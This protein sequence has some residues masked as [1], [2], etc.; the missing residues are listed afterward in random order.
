MSI[1]QTADDGRIFQSDDIA[2]AQYGCACVD[3]EHQFGLV[4]HHLA[5]CTDAGGEILVPQAESGSGEVIQAAHQSG[6]QQRLGLVAA[7]LAGHQYLCGGRGFG[8]GILAVH[9][10]D[11]ILAE[12]D[13]EEDAQDAAQQGADEHLG[14]GHGHLGR[15]TLLQDVKCGQGED[16][17]RHDD[18]RRGADGLDDDILAQ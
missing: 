14:K 11:E 12:R 16:G 1:H 17:T 7:L 9:V 8:E 15:I 5:P 10:A 13:E 18:A 6:G 3:L 2:Q 4:R